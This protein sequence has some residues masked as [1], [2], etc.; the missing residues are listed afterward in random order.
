MSVSDF[1]QRLGVRIDSRH[2]KIGQ[3]P[4]TAVTRGDLAPSPTG[5]DA[6]EV[7]TLSLLLTSLEHECDDSIAP[8]RRVPPSRAQHPADAPPRPAA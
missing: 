2:R 3:S 8:R 1:I 6:W 5:P 7:E 4:A